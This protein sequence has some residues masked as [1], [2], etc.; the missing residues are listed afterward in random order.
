[1]T[2]VRTIAFVLYPGL[3]PL[4]LIGPLQVINALAANGLPYRSVTV[5]H[6][7]DPLPTDLPLRLTASHT[8]AEVPEPFALLVPGG[9]TPTYRAMADETVLAYLRTAAAKAELV[10]SVCT[11]SLVLGAAG[12]L[13]GRRATTHWAVREV[14]RKF[15]ATPV[16]ERWVED[17]PF[18]TA[19]GVAA[20]IDAALHVVDRLAGEEVARF[21]QTV[22]EYDPQ[23]PHGPIDWSTVDLSEGMRW[24]E[25]WVKEALGDH[26]ELAAKLLG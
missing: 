11:G 13:E 7:T 9:G 24:H 20:G 2:D 18:I 3:T 5:S 16:A 8:F 1:M 22:I 15:G 21:V 12:L 25:M 10:L 19:A 26:P 4:D 6:T 14:L 17:G 23:P